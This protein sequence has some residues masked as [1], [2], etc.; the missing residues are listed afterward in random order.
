V[1]KVLQVPLALA[2]LFALAFL[3]FYM[4]PNVEQRKGRVFVAAALT[5][6]LWI[7]ATLL[8]RLYVQHFPPNPA[9]GAI[10]GVIILLTWMYYTMFVILLGGEFASELHHGTG[11]LTPNAGAIY[12]GRLV[13]DSGPGSTSVRRA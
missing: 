9:Y 11:A 10:G 5:T 1:W 4:L 2:G 7:A 12:V 13:T 6:I 8:F 3:A